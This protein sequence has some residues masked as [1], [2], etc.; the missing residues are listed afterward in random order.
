[1]NRSGPTS[2]SRRWASTNSGLPMPSEH[3]LAMMMVPPGSRM[4][5]TPTI[6][7]TVW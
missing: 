2:H 4:S 5:M 3:S 1:M 6:P 7:L